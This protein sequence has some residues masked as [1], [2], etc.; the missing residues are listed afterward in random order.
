MPD[1]AL[2][3][4][5][6]QFLSLLRSAA[7][8]IDVTL[9]LYALPDVPRGEAGQR[10]IQYFYSGVEDLMD[11]HLDGLIITG[12]EP[13][14]PNLTRE[15]YWK[16]LTQ[17][18]DWAE[19]NVHSTVLS[20]LA[21]HAGLQHFDGIVRCPMK[22]KCFGILE[23]KKELDHHLTAGVPN[24]FDIPHSRWNGISENGLSE[25]GYQVLSRTPDG[26]I[27]MLVRQSRSLFV[28]FQGHPEYEA[29][30]LFL[31]YRRDVGR[32]LNGERDTYPVLPANYFDSGTADV[33]LGLREQAL[34]HRHRELFAYLPTALPEKGIPSPWHFAATRVYR[35]WLEYLLQT[36]VTSRVATAYLRQEVDTS[37]GLPFLSY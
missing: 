30:T 33:L 32:Y 18:L 8:D 28:L 20:C 35:N 25:R 3:A 24:R 12:A 16:S 4:T 5:E 11:G 37:T 14:A 6:H 17:V 19:H 15:P 29:N 27:D 26:S 1:G 36:R 34:R 23:C 22:E 9:S 10:H 21:A 7:G 2:K 13:S 31:E